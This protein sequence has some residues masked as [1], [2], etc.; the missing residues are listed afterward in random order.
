MSP[1]Q[2]QYMCDLKQTLDAGVSTSSDAGITLTENLGPLRAGN[3]VWYGKDG[4][5]TL[6]H[7]LVYAGA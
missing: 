2:Y 5:P 1:E 3:A 7:R 6:A 4:I